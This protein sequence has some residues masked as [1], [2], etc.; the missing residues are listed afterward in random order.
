MQKQRIIL[1][2]GVLLGIMAIFSIKVYMDNQQKLIMQQAQEEL[3]KRTKNSVSVLYAKANIGRGSTIDADSFEA[4]IIPKEYAD[5][6]AVTS[7]DR[8]SGMTTIVDITKGEQIT[9]NK[10]N[11]TGGISGGLAEATPMGKRAV[12][13]SVDNVSALAGMLRPGNYVDVLTMVPV[14]MMGADGKQVSQLITVPLFQNVLVLA[15]GRQI[16]NVTARTAD[17][18]GQQEEKKESSPLVTLALNPQETNLIAYVQE[19]SKIKL[20]LRST[21]DAKIEPMKPA[22]LDTLLSY[23]FPPQPQPPKKEEPPKHFVEIYRGMEKEKVL[24]PE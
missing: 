13:V 5:P 7:L 16:E 2:S 24:L 11:Y 8:I 10:L 14:P 12:T 6:Q 4:K 20:V 3:K 9:L 21:A 19:Q 22:T 17:R 15:V 1:I 18:Y 23:I